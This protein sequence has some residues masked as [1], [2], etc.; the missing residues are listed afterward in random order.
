MVAIVTAILMIFGGHVEMNLVYFHWVSTTMHTKF[1]LEISVRSLAIDII[2]WFL[3]NTFPIVAAIFV[4]IL[5]FF[6]K[7]SQIGLQQ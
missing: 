4:A 2:E 5:N 3:L 6:W 1:G 7:Y